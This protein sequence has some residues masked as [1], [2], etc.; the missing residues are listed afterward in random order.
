M[1]LFWQLLPDTPV[2]R[3]VRSMS[4]SQ[5]Q[6]ERMRIAA[7]LPVLMLPVLVLLALVAA[8]DDA[9]PAQDK[10]QQGAPPAQAL[11]PAAAPLPAAPQDTGTDIGSGREQTT[12]PKT[13]PSPA[14]VTPV[15]PLPPTPLTVAGSSGA[16]Q[17]L[18]PDTTRLPLARVLQIAL[19]AVP[20]EVIDAELDD[21]DDIP[22]YEVKILTPA[23]RSMEVKIDARRGTVLK[24]ED[25]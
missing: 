24:V 3:G 11:P 10:T 18:M 25:D 5:V 17:A 13:M 9:P 1:T 14:P 4:G 2:T 19:R 23:G 8:C 21:D 16:A 6:R 22:E 7:A 12:P 20:G 15:A